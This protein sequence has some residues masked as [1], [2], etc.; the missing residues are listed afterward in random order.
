[1]AET[2]QGMLS[3]MASSQLKVL[4]QPTKESGATAESGIGAFT[5]RARARLPGAPNAELRAPSLGLQP[6]QCRCKPAA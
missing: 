1:M 6:S 2:G 4:N 5:P 3:A